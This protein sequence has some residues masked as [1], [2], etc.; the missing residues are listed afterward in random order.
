MLNEALGGNAEN[1]VSE[2]AV[3][4]TGLPSGELAVMTATPAVCSANAERNA[5]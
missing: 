1:D 2:V 5:S 3:K 4:P